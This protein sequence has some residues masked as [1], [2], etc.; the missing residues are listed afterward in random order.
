M[1]LDGID[2]DWAGHATDILSVTGLGGRGVKIA[3]SPEARL[4][5]R[6]SGESHYEECEDRFTAGI[7]GFTQLRFRLKR[8]KAVLRT[9]GTAG[10][11]GAFLNFLIDPYRADFV[12]AGLGY[13]VA[14]IVC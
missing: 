10:L 3:K 2:D 11:A 5:G 9:C 6:H 12:F 1:P 7:F 8:L 4:I 13:G 14:S